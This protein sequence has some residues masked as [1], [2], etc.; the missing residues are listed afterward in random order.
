[1]IQKLGSEGVMLSNIYSVAGKFDDAAQ[2]RIIQ[3]NK[4]LKK[5][6]GCSWVEI[7]R[8]IKR[9]KQGGRQ[10]YLKAIAFKDYVHQLV[11]LLDCHKK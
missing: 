6:P 10:T 2:I 9:E 11:R 3:R 7:K 4:G 5:I 1:M 8:T